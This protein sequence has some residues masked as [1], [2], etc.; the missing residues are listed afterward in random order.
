MVEAG[1]P[2]VHLRYQLDSLGT[3]RF[4]GTLPNGFSAHPKYDPATGEL[5]A[6]AYHWP[7][8]VDHVQY[9]VVGADGRVSK[10]LDVP[11]PDMPMIHDMSLTNTYALVYD[12]PVTVNLDVV[13]EG[14]P[15]PFSWAPDRAARVG[16]L[17]RS[18]TAADIIWCDV[19]PCY[20]FHPLNAYDADDGTVVVDVCRYDRMMDTDRRGPFTDSLSTFDRWV[21]DPVAKRVFE[22]RLDDRP[23]EFPRHDPRVGLRRH[24]F[25]YTSEVSLGG[26]NLHGAILKHDLDAG[27]TEAHEFGPGR[28]GAEPLVVPKA[29]SN[30]EDDAWILPVVYDPAS[31]ASELCILD[32][33]DITGP[34][35]ARIELP[36]RVPF[37]FHGNWVSDTSVAPPA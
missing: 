26:P 3:N 8:L 19:D 6:M 21:I 36:Q 4:F 17:P 5:H 1:T 31:D 13:V 35:V 37:G 20:V 12:L 2:P 25:G 15:W 7:D 18:G 23:Q 30:A 10:V 9:V 24:R 29:D 11:V 34:E 32:A 16:L 28:G 33:Q 27:T 14:Y 22:T